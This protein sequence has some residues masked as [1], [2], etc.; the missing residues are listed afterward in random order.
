[1]QG[2]P[3]GGDEQIRRD[4]VDAVEKAVGGV[5][6][7]GQLLAVPESVYATTGV[8]PERTIILVVRELRV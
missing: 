3:D 4:R 5:T 8:A 6:Q 2:D 1:V 7:A